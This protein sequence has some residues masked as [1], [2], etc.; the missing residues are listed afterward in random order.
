MNS[1][2]IID[3]ILFLGISQGFF[4]AITIQLVQHKNTA[5]NKILSYILLIAAFM[6]LGRFVYF[7][8]SSYLLLQLASFTDGIIFLFGPFVY[9]YIRR[10]T[11][12]E[13][14]TYKLAWYNYL[15]VIY[16]CLISG[17]FLFYSLE[18]F[19]ILVKN[20]TIPLNFIYNSIVFG[21][22]FSNLYYCLKSFLLV[23]AFHKEQKNNLSYYQNA[24]SFL[25]TFLSAIALFLVL[26]GINFTGRFFNHK[27]FSLFNYDFVWVSIPLFIYVV[28]FYSLKQP[29]IFRIRLH[30]TKEKNNKNRLEGALLI[31]L[32]NRLEILMVK[33]KIYL[34]NT[35]TLKDLSEKIGTS[36]NN[37]SWLL[38][39]IHNC[40]FYDFINKY[41]VEAFIEKI[42]NGE[43]EQHTLLALSMDAGFNSKSTFNKAFKTAMND[44]PSNYIKKISIV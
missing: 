19:S 32:Q 42:Q 12:N 17:W 24:I 2:G 14:P 21:G 3:L 15:P 8:N 10:F 28:G 38:N 40:S 7:R 16:P 4:L 44:T 18:E 20:G 26:W 35:L 37:V 13:V 9:T 1:F 22:L 11:F 25:Y 43:H 27:V 39:N 41:R 6:L 33:D 30:K 34:N 23:K 5:A 29:E 36:P 31:Q